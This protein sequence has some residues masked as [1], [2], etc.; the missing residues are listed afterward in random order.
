MS[1]M[2]AYSELALHN[3]IWVFQSFASN[4]WKVQGYY[5]HPSVFFFLK[6]YRSEYTIKLSE[7]AIANNEHGPGYASLRTRSRVL[8]LKKCFFFLL[9]CTVT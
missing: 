2:D 1:S 4:Q 7:T 5:E 3:S 6:V 8:P 9:T